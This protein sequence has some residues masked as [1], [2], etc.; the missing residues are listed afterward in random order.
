MKKIRKLFG[1]IALVVIIELI[2]SCKI[3]VSEPY[4]YDELREANTQ[5]RL[6]I[7]G[8]DDYEGKVISAQRAGL[9]DTSYDD[10]VAFGRVEH[11]YLNGE[12]VRGIVTTT[13]ATVVNGEVSLKVYNYDM[14]SI[15][16]GNYNGNDKDVLFY[17]YIMGT[18]DEMPIEGTVS[19]NFTNGIGS[20]IFVLNTN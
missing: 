6:T 5:G 13:G 15:F 3:E 10:L 11:G 19:V 1:L 16:F 18:D 9:G 7:T 20:G 12:L 17:V 14:F 8:L 4:S 2:V